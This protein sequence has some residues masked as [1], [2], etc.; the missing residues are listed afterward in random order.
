MTS[1]SKDILK[2]ID[3]MIDGQFIENKKDLT[4]EFRGSSNQRI[5]HKGQDF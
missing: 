2:Y 3:V 5:L 4:L 1:K